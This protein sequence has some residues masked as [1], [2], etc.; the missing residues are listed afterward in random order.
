MENIKIIEYTNKK[1][2]QKLLEIKNFP[3]QLYVIGNEELLNKDAIAIVGSRECTPYGAYY[4]KKFAKEIAK[5][6]ICIVSG[7]AIGI[8][9]EA[10]IGAVKE[11]GKTI[12][13]LR[14][15]F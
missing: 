13:V 3:K 11:K 10:H 2:P 4:S 14:C 6:G 8:D 7:M 9:T 1:Y 15:R 12:A 5:E